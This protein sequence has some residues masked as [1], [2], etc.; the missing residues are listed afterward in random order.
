M[1]T[2]NKVSKY[3]LY[4]IGEIV[5][6]VIGILIALQI[7][8]SNEQRKL[9]KQEQYLLLQ[10]QKEFK[11]D[12]INLDRFAFL[13]GKKVR[14]GKLL[15]KI[16]TD[17]IEVSEDSVI[18]FAFFNGKAVLFSGYTPTFDEMVSSGN[19]AVIKSDV[20]K[21]KIKRYKSMLNSQQSFLYYEAQRRKETY[22][23]HL[24][25]YFEP[26][27]MTFIWENIGFGPVNLKGLEAYETDIDGFFNDPKTLYH[28]NTIIGVDSELEQKYK[29]GYVFGL[30][31]ILTELQLEIDKTND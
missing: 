12:S 6:V 14:E 1:L 13:S 24:F 16:I 2:E 23:T 10:M 20:L 8:N 3:L 19:L 31:D 18:A 30:N 22:N 27:I 21:G 5:L 17:K 28:I 9:N 4:A 7:N 15:R 26:E 11:A 25:K 29:R